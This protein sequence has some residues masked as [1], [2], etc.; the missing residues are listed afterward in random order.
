MYHIFDIFHFLTTGSE[1]YGTDEST[2]LF[3]V[4]RYIFSPHTANSNLRRHLYEV[5]GLET[6]VQAPQ[7]EELD[8]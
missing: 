1:K 7:T 2:I 3:G 4:A 5:H 8:E 6:D